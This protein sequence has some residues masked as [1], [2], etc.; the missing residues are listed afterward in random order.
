MGGA[1]FIIVATS[2]APAHGK[3]VQQWRRISHSLSKDV[4]LVLQDLES[5]ATLIVEVPAAA[6]ALGSPLHDRFDAVR[7]VALAAPLHSLLTVTGVGFFD[8]L[9]DARGQ[10]PNGFELPRS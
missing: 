7:A 4:H 9:H 6:C 1:T 3:A 10:A 8:F 5:E 2:S